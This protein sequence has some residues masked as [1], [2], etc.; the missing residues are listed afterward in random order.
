MLEKI[1]TIYA[2]AGSVITSIV[3]MG[4]MGAALGASGAGSVMA[5]GSSSSS[6]IIA[7]LLQ[8]IGLGFL[9]QIPDAILRPFLIF[10]LLIT[11]FVAYFSYKRRGNKAALSLTILSSIA[12][13]FSI[14]IFA[15]ELLY[16]VSF[17]FLGIAAFYHHKCE[18]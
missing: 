1:K 2:H 12:V 15:S 5:M 14:Y 17:I 13:Y 11:I 10:A 8:A 6:L 9:T 3:C 4:Q 18:K 7:S 16:F